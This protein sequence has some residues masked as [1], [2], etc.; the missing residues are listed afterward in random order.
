VLVMHA[1]RP[2]LPPSD[3]RV[4]LTALV[5][6]TGLSALADQA[7]LIVAMARLA[8]LALPPWW[9]P[10]LKLV[11]TLAYVLLAPWAAAWADHLPKPRTLRACTLLKAAG[12]ACLLFGGHPL[13]ALA[14]AGLGAAG[15]APARYGWVA[16][17][18][19]LARLVSANAWLEGTMVVSSLLGIGL[20]GWLVRPGGGGVV[21]ATAALLLLQALAWLLLLRLAAPPVASRRATRRGGARRLWLGFAATQ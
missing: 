14:L 20:G 9:A 2:A 5:L 12:V 11:F 13:P 3:A 19:P 16:E 6:A 10:L 17:Q 15:A 21:A 8:E 7:L 4:S 18:L 1:P